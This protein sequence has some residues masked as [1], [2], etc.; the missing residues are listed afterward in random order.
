MK[1]RIWNTDGTADGDL[2]E[3]EKADLEAEKNSGTNGQ[4]KDDNKE[5]ETNKGD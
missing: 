3:D 5:D 1:K 4:G 2:T